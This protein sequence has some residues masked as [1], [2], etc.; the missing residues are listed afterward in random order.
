MATLA[1]PLW[2]GKSAVSKLF[3][4][5]KLIY[6]SGCKTVF[7]SLARPSLGLTD[8]T[9][10]GLAVILTPLFPSHALCRTEKLRTRTSLFISHCVFFF[11]F[12]ALI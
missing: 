8:E 12:F 5:Q 11:F 6:S 3:P 9:R 10:H 4:A 1:T 7:T 2:G